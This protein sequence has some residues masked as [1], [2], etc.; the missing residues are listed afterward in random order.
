[1]TA[2]PGKKRSVAH[3][4]TVL[5]ISCGFMRPAAAPA[6]CMRWHGRRWVAQPA[7][8]CVAQ[9]GRAA[10]TPNVAMPSAKQACHIAVPPLPPPHPPG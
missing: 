9:P 10:P 6:A 2:A 1:M 5:A 8:D 4:H 7:R 3:A